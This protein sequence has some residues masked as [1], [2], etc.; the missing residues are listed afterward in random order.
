M[1]TSFIIFFLILF[2][3]GFPQI[4]HYV[5]PDENT[6][7]KIAEAV[8]LPIYGNSIYKNKPFTAA[9]IGDSIWNVSGTLPHPDTT[10]FN[11]NIKKIRV[12]FGGVPFAK[13]RKDDGKIIL[14]IHGK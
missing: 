1:K 10:I 5:V 8:W 13:I 11:G 2:L 6:A 12:H 3:E 7:I 4:T 9:L 14:I